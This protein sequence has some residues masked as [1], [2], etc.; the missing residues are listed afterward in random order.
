M[1]LGLL[2]YRINH[3]LEKCNF[4]NEHVLNREPVPLTL[5]RTIINAFPI[6]LINAKN[7][8]DDLYIRCKLEL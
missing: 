1:L 8:S 2:N 6:L 5:F 3:K 4:I 7:L